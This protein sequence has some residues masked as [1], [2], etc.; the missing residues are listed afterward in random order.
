[1]S[2][3][4]ASRGRSLGAL[5]YGRH[6]MLIGG[7]AAVLAATS[8]WRPS[9]GAAVS[10]GLYGAL[11][12]STLAVSLRAPQPLRRKLLFV[13]IAASLSMLSVTMGLYGG[14]FIGTLP[15]MV[16]PYVLLAL[17]SGFGAASY[18]VLVRRFWIADLPLRALVSITLGCV[19]VTLAVLMSGIPLKT[20]GSLWFAVFWWFAFSAGLW[21]H[22]AT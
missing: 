16:G 10:C 7:I 1:M 19:L 17:V 6:F 11:H 12:A 9:Q 21:H 15:G 13:A 18:A 2:D 14:R 3:V 22:E 20:V 4:T 5:Y 8:S